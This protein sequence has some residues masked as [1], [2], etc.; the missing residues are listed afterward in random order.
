MKNIITQG[1]QCCHHTR[2]GVAQESGPG[3]TL[4]VS[5]HLGNMLLHSSSWQATVMS[6]DLIQ[7][8]ARE[9]RDN[10]C[11]RS[12][13]SHS[14]AGACQFSNCATPTSYGSQP[15]HL[16]I[17]LLLSLSHTH[18]HTHS[19]QPC[20]DTPASHRPWLRSAVLKDSRTNML[21]SLRNSLVVQ[22]LPA[23]M[24]G[25]AGRGCQLGEAECAGVPEESSSSLVLSSPP[26][27]QKPRPQ[28]HSPGACSLLRRKAHD[29]MS[30]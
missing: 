12:D 9:T 18:T 30:L 10:P 16:S 6:S 5:A 13:H 2:T 20:N 7:H 17:S 8:G 19:L 27:Q 4:E 29:M 28:V 14:Q 23:N 21:R 15:L 3:E 25:E 24:P 1:H 22:A 11:H 26:S